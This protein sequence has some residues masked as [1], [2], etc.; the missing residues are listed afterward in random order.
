MH[1]AMVC[2]GAPPDARTPECVLHLIARRPDL[3]PQRVGVLPTLLLAC[4][5]ALRDESHD[6]VWHGGRGR[7][8]SI[9]AQAE[10]PVELEQRRFFGGRG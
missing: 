9:Q 10:D 3:V 5:L 2:M 6:L 8:P 7:L 1:L 4:L